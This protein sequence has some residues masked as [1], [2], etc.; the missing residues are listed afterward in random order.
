MRIAGTTTVTLA[1]L[2]LTMASEGATQERMA[3]GFM[4][5]VD[6]GAA[7]EWLPFRVAEPSPVVGAR[8]SRPEGTLWGP[9]DEAR[10]DVTMGDG[11]M[12]LSLSGIHELL[13]GRRVRPYAIGGVGSYVTDQGQLAVSLGGG[14]T[15]QLAG[16][17]VF[18][19]GRGALGGAPIHRDHLSVSIGLLW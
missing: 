5:G 19:E 14:A 4:G 1:V 8:F 15:V 12:L 6:V 17:R 9:V 10:V 16:R 2:L 13:P 3:V 11:F 18:V 7:A